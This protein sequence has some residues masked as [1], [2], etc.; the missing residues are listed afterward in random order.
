ML[1]GD[2]GGTLESLESL[3]AMVLLPYSLGSLLLLFTEPRSRLLHSGCSVPSASRLPE[4]KA[5][6]QQA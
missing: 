2:D 3:G 4:E 1:G 5:A 6:P